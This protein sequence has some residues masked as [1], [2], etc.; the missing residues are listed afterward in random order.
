MIAWLRDLPDT[1]VFVAVVAPVVLLTLGALRLQTRS[2]KEGEESS[3]GFDSFLAVASAAAVLLAFSLVQVDSATHA[4]DE[5]VSKEAAA[6]NSTDRVL[7]RYGDPQMTALRPILLDYANAIVGDEW[8]RLALGER[9]VKVDE[10]YTALSK[11][12]R[13]AE[14]T[15]PRQQTMYSEI[16]KYLD[17]LADLRE[18]R[19][20]AANNG[21]PTMFWIAVG[22]MFLLM[23]ILVARLEPRTERLW[24]TGA[25]AGAIGVLLAVIIVVEA[26]FHGESNSVTS[27]AIQRAVEQ[28]T[29]RH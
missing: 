17:D 8:P 7:T 22:M 9:S 6:I 1:L 16:L 23:L 5:A 29:K 13:I 28:M 21:L 27:D 15:T 2:A 20:S 18:Q 4:T 12:A 10:L 26:P 3:E 25:I 14:P 19:I 24:T 11:S